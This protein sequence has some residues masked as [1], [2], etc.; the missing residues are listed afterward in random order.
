MPRSENE[1]FEPPMKDYAAQALK[2][3]IHNGNLLRPAEN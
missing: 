3:A 1:K 2:K